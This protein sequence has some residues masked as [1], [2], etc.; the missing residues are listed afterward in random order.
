[1]KKQLKIFRKGKHKGTKRSKTKT[2]DT[3]LS[4]QVGGANN[5]IPSGTESTGSVGHDSTGYVEASS[6]ADTGSRA[7]SV[8]VYAAEE[9]E[10]DI[11]S[12]C[13]GGYVSFGDIASDL[14][15]PGQEAESDLPRSSS[16]PI[17]EHL[18]FD[19][20]NEGSPE[21]KGL[22]NKQEQDDA[23][24]VPKKSPGL[25]HL[26]TGSDGYLKPVSKKKNLG[27]QVRDFFRNFGQAFVSAFTRN[28]NSPAKRNL[29]DDLIMVPPKSNSSRGVDGIPAQDPPSPTHSS[30]GSSYMEL[31]ESARTYRIPAQGAVPSTVGPSG[32][33]TARQIDLPE[34]YMVTTTA[35]IHRDGE[36]QRSAFVTGFRRSAGRSNSE[37]SFAQ[38]IFNAVDALPIRNSLTFLDAPNPFISSEPSYTSSVPS[39]KEQSIADSQSVTSEAGSQQQ[40]SSEKPS[41]AV[42]RGIVT[43]ESASL[44]HPTHIHNPG[45]PMNDQAIIPS[46]SSEK[47]EE[48]LAGRAST[49]Q[50]RRSPQ[51]G[52]LSPQLL[53]TISVRLSLSRA[54]STGESQKDI[55]KSTAQHSP[56]VMGALQKV[57]V[58]SRFSDTQSTSGVAAASTASVSEA[59]PSTIKKNAAKSAATES[60]KAVG[61]FQRLLGRSANAKGL[62]VIIPVTQASTP[63]PEIRVPSLADLLEGRKNL[64]SVSGSSSGSVFQQEEPIYARSTKSSSSSS[65]NSVS[66]PS[67]NEDVA[68]DLPPRPFFDAQ[69]TSK[70]E[71]EAAR[72]GS[73]L[74]ERA[75]F[76]DVSTQKVQESEAKAASESS[77]SRAATITRSI[78]PVRLLETKKKAPAVK[79]PVAPKSASV[80][81]AT[82]TPAQR[83]M[84]AFSSFASLAS[85]SAETKQ[86]QPATFNPVV[87]ARS[88]A[89]SVPNLSGSSLQSCTPSLVKLVAAK[90]SEPAR[91]PSPAS[92]TKFRTEV[93]IQLDSASRPR[94][95]SASPSSSTVSVR[96][97]VS[98]K[99]TVSAATAGKG[100]EMHALAG[101]KRSTRVMKNASPGIKRSVE[102]LLNGAE[103]SAATVSSPNNSV[104]S[105]SA[106]KMFA[107]D[108]TQNKPSVPA[109]HMPS[110]ANF[111]V[112]RMV[113]N[114]MKAND[115]RET[116]FASRKS[117]DLTVKSIE[118]RLQAERDNVSGAGNVRHSMGNHS[119]NASMQRKSPQRH[120][121]VSVGHVDALVRKFSSPKRSRVGELVQK[122][123]G[124]HSS[125]IA[126]E[127]SKQQRGR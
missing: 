99:P 51:V 101:V 111:A 50:T 100:K 57:K 29:F 94:V 55:A 14:D 66:S 71:E 56:G 64:K 96:E 47:R 54:F 121:E 80:A 10:V 84:H 77:V 125:A 65:S 46:S 82:F 25:R 62:K 103:K 18:D 41:V 4:Q 52:R 5:P 105:G 70:K 32:A 123:E 53:D 115:D 61:V 16:T 12:S 106:L 38:E 78:S 30:N 90:P 45:N 93:S 98:N 91:S 1:M 39:R 122:F 88:P 36:P 119:I 34:E 114:S 126:S 81:A 79:P 3:S 68:P 76:L 58:F 7:G 112:I 67:D 20:D 8:H 17:Y 21:S 15:E 24:E 44:D 37:G 75:V 83:A 28:K 127:T 87:I 59:G 120:G 109:E 9:D 63:S 73:P 86:T 19:F 92:P 72:A 22:T 107:T 95:P 74:S 27:K 26:S 97:Q 85:T 42:N 49:L 117:V 48:K 60:T 104:N 31:G 43:S 33:Q 89:L 40:S 102:M 69:Q 110:A 35:Q 108:F 118:S 124:K 6:R 13:E 113:K 116:L 23:P 11:P 2:R